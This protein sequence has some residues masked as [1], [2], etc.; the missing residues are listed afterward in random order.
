MPSN[1]SVLPIDQPKTS[2]EIQNCQRINDEEHLKSE[3]VSIPCL[4]SAWNPALRTR[5]RSCV[6]R[7]CHYE[8]YVALE[9]KLSSEF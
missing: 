4:L 1:Q 8:H 2:A 9:A 7:G 6:P 5:I 3:K